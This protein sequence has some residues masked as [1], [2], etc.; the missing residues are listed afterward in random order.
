MRDAL[1]DGHIGKGLGRCVGVGGHSPWLLIPDSGL[2]RGLCD[3]G[4]LNRAMLLVMA[5]RA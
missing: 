4:E 1:D 2:I 5:V 3:L